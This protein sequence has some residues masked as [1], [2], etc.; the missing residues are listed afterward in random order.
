M[1]LLITVIAVGV[2]AVLDSQSQLCVLLLPGAIT[3]LAVDT[4]IVFGDS[5]QALQTER[6]GETHQHTGYS[7]GTL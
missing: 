4:L 5:S 6:E 3:T 7:E 2:L 1:G